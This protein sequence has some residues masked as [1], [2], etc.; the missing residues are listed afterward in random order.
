MLPNKKIG[1]ARWFVGMIALILVISLLSGCGK[2]NSG[3]SA[4]SSPIATKGPKDTDIAGTYKDGKVTYGELNKFI[5]TSAFL[6]Q[7]SA[8][9]KGTPGFDEYM[10]KQYVLL[11]VL[12]AR[13]S[14]ASKKDAE[15]KVKTQM[16]SF[17]KYYDTNKAQMD[18]AMK[19]ANIAIA[20]IQNYFS[21]TLIALSDMG[22]KVTDQQIKAEYDKN[23]KADPYAY[24]TASLQHILV[25]LKDPADPTGQKDLRTKDEALKRALE[26]KD[27]LDKGGD[28]T[29]LAKE[30]S[31]DPGSKDN[32]GKYDN[33]SLSTYVAAFKKAAAELPLNKISD[34]V[35]TEYG[36]HVMKV[37]SRTNQTVDQ[38]K[39]SIRSSLEDGLINDFMTNEF[40]KLDY[41]SAIPTPSPAPTPAPTPVGTAPATVAPAK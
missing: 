37:L 26:V 17:Q 38:A 8:Q 25:M 10:L 21:M 35:E 12:N 34:P 7:Q 19:A 5:E 1:Q 14:D 23:I 27:K 2:T 36:Y 33:A 18:P 15:A 9:A 28:F 30:Y 40:P 39:E 11:K 32:G 24:T 31:D 22:T 3:A 29:A 20:D 13:A 4:S 16:D 6:S 41:K